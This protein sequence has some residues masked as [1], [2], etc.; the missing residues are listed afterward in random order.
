MRQRTFTKG[1]NKI[2]AIL[3][4]KI[5]IMLFVL[6][7][8]YLLTSTPV[9][10]GIICQ[11]VADVS[12]D[13]WFPD[14]NLN[15]KDRIIISTNKNI[16]HGIARGL[17]LFDIPEE[18]SADDITSASIF[19]SLC[20]HCG[21]GDGGAVAFYALNKPFDEE[22]DTWNSLEGGKWD[23]S[24]GAPGII[25]AGNDWN[26]AVNGEPPADAEGIDI[27]VLL[28]QNLQKVRENGIIMRFADEHQEPY[29]HQNIA[30]KESDDLLDFA[31]YIVLNDDEDD[32]PCP[33]ELLLS[34]THS[35]QL[36]LLRI[37]RDHVLSTTVLGRLAIKMYYS[38]A[39]LISNI[40]LKK[41][42]TLP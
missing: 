23:E 35:D 18:L 15:Y 3:V 20:S 7:A 42:L 27:T 26:E 11:N 4:G 38:S 34:K 36:S 28:K 6:M 19:L 13:E 1:I 31:P 8:F 17:F 30:S 41:G 32:T 10:A 40:L 39:P 9:T 2:V 12:I 29:T 33:A 16:H 21:G 37:Y 14:E 24:L 25:P 5:H 22:T